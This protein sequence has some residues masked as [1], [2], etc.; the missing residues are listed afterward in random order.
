MFEMEIKIKIQSVD[1]L[2][3]LLAQLKANHKVNLKHNDIYFNKPPRIGDF[4]QSDEALRLRSSTEID[5]NTNKILLTNNDLTYKG[6][7]LDQTVKTRIE[8][9][10]TLIDPAQMEAILLALGFIK[11]ISIIKIR[12]VHLL[13]FMEHRIECLIDCVE[14]L[15]GTYFEAEILVRNKEDMPAIKKILLNFLKFLGYSESD[16]IVESYLELVLKKI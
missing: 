5:P 4:S 6:P 16:T 14:N 15:E 3:A 2:R 1:K 9:V 12:E 10:C 8:H 13:N 11:V 7:K